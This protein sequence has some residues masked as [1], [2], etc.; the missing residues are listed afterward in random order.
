VQVIP[1]LKKCIRG[2]IFSSALIQYVKERKDE[3]INEKL[4]LEKSSRKQEQ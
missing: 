2:I 4:I 3:R 1:Y